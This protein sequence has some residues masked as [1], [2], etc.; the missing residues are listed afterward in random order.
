MAPN[1]N[2]TNIEY[3]SRK[4]PNKSRIK[5][6]YLNYGSFFLT[7]QNNKIVSEQTIDE[8]SFAE[9]LRIN[10]RGGY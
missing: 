6:K 10:S 8:I 5:P 2:K 3:I 4:K 7:T 1:Q 9:G